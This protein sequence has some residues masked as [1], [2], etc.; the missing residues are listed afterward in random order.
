MNDSELEKKLKAAREPA[1]L[2][3]YQASFPQTVLANL[4]SDTWKTSPPRHSRLSRLAWALATAACLV[5]AFGIGHWHGRV[6]AAAPTSLLANARLIHETMAMF[7][8]QVRAITQDE[9]G[10]KLILA[11]Q[12]NVPDSPPLYVKICDGEKCSSLVTF[13]GQEIQIGG[14]KLTVLA[15]VSGGIIL[16]GNKFVWSTTTRNYAGKGLRI[17]A[18]PL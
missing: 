16:E 15:D 7:P 4:R 5:L 12:A 11:D 18:R 9:H 1:L 2:K 14:Q 6:E 13:S 10:M 8:N 17:E 3:E